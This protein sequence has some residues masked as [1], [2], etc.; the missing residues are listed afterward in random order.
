MIKI[1]H[2]LPYQGSKRK[3]AP[4]IIQH[5]NFEIDTL[6]EPFAGSAA[7]TLA[8]AANR[9]ANKYIISDK[10]QS[11]ADLWNFVIENPKEASEYYS[12]VWN[13]QLDDP[14]E[15]FVKVRDR[16]NRDRN[17]IDFLYLT[18]RSVKNAIR[19]N[20]NGEFNQSPDNRRLG[21]HPNKMTQEIFAAALLLKDQCSVLSTDFKDIIA[22]ATSNDLIYMDPPWQGTSNK[23][24]PRYAYL[25][26]IEDLIEQLYVLNKKN[27][28]YILSFDGICGDKSYGNDLPYDLNLHKIILDAGRSTQA[29]LLGRNEKTFESLYL[30]ESCLLKNRMSKAS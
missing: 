9:I 15:Y 25:L 7:I 2:V 21:T 14:K 3:L 23:R 18:A 22:S 13:A 11:I 29:T 1:P 26:N 8:A 6:Y 27:I 4:H 12:N 24:N 5:M 10:L 17:P 16:F 19:F 20:S 30:S 28:P